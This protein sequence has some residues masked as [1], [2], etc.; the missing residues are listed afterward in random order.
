VAFRDRSTREGQSL[1]KDTYRQGYEI[2][3]D[4]IADK[5]M[6]FPAVIIQRPARRPS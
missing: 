1:I 6:V 2:R 5:D 3:I 4:L